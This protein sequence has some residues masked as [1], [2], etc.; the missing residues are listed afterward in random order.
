ML[1]GSM[2]LS[3]HISQYHVLLI[4]AAEVTIS[5]TGIN[6]ILPTGQ[7]CRKQGGEKSS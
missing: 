2:M 5:E 4:I 1:Q 6:V 7:N 3:P